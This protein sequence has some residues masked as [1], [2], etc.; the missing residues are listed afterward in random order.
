LESKIRVAVVGSGQLATAARIPAFLA[1]KDVDLVALVDVDREKTEKAA[2]KFG[3]RKCFTSVDELFENEYVDAVSVCTPPNTHADI[4]LKALNNGAHVLCEKPMANDI[5]NAKRMFEVSKAKEKILMV[6]SYRRFVPNFRKAKES[7]REGKL[8]HVYCIEDMQLSPSPLLTWGKSPWYYEP[9]GG[10]VL[11]DLGPHCFDLINYL[12]GDFPIAVSA[13][14]LTH[15]DS[16]VEEACVCMLEYPENR[17]GVGT[18]SWLSSITM[19]NTSI[20]GTVESIFVSQKFFIEANRVDIPEISLLREVGSRLVGL[21]FPNF[22]LLH[23]GKSV[24]PLQLETNCF[25]KQMKQNRISTLNS[26]NAFKVL[27]TI[28][29]AKRALQEKRKIEISSIEQ[30]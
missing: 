2:R 22:P 27:A 20:H 25:V 8:G 18:M 5:K 23:A 11:F 14:S 17:V 9:E 13:H 3:I 15:L 4:A 29:A 28:Y 12:F 1:N 21:K 6:S 30:V 24:D 19:E 16:P 10:G 26:L 7:I